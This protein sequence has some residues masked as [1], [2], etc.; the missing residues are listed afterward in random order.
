MKDEKYAG[1]IRWHSTGWFGIQVGGSFWIFICAAML[2]NVNRVFG[3]LVF[4][5]FAIPNIVGTMLWHHRERTPPYYAMQLLLLLIG[6]CSYSAVALL[7]RAEFFGF[8]P[9]A[10][11]PAAHQMYLLLGILLSIMMGILYLFHRRDR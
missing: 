9:W 11:H 8:H 5:C 1:K 6:S 7:N 4:L 10:T 3:V 2:M